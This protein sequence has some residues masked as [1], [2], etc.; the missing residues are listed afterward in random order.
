VLLL[1]RLYPQADGQTPIMGA[2]N[3]ERPQYDQQRM[4]G[5]GGLNENHE[6]Q[7]KAD[8]VILLTKEGGSKVEGSKLDLTIAHGS[9]V[10]KS[11]VGS[12][13]I[14]NSVVSGSKVTSCK[15]D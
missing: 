4:E 5:Q 3:P 1:T 8:L 10:N 6:D 9:D 7:L 15:I 12:S 14:L 2:Y 13:N 11:F